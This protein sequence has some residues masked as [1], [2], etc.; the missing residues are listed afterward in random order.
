MFNI[1]WRK[2]IISKIN[3]ESHVPMKSHLV[4]WVRTTLRA[5]P[6][7]PPLL[8]LVCV[9]GLHVSRANP[10][11][12]SS[13]HGFRH[14]VSLAWVWISKRGVDVGESPLWNTV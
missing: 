3:H 14:L 10:D 9:N 4:V 6:R 1:P 7:L 5:T 13:W 12:L 11:S 2:V 8:G